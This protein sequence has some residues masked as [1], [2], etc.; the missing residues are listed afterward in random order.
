MQIYLYS[1]LPAPELPI[2]RRCRKEGRAVAD[3]NDQGPPEPPQQRPAG[4]GGPPVAGGKDHGPPATGGKDH[5]PPAAE[6]KDHGPPATGGKDHGSP[7]AAETGPG[8]EPGT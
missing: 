7:A 8:G 5:G 3:A 6:G 2:A 1:Q 4:P